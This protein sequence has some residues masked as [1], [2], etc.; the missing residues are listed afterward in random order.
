MFDSAKGTDPKTGFSFVPSGGEVK[1]DQHVP[2][3][4]EVKTDHDT[5]D[6][7]MTCLVDEMDDS[8]LPGR[9]GNPNCHS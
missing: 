3:G 1:T 8:P 6:V 4:G 7:Q 9:A 2:S 5:F